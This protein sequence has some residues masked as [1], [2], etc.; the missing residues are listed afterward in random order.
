MVSMLALA[1]AMSPAA[2]GAAALG[3]TTIA[4][5]AER[6]A[7]AVVNID[8]VER[9]RNPMMEL[10][11]FFHGFFGPEGRIP[12]FLESKGVGSGFVVDVGGLVLTNWHVVRS[13]QRI[14]VTFP[15][16]R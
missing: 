2:A 11:P 5:L 8:T 13:A 14:F 7:P 1:T 12:P 10:D 4:D 6:A 3:P 9:R 16:G 15:D